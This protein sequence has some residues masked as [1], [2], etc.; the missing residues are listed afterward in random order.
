L[1]GGGFEWLLLGLLGPSLG[2]SDDA[3]LA[4]PVVGGDVVGAAVV[5][6]AVLA[7]TLGDAGAVVRGELTA[8]PSVDELQPATSAGVPTSA[9]AA[10]AS[11]TRRMRTW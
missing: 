8:V 11:R 7:G 1:A 5:S 10:A 2:P 6:G 9:T 3:V 4:G